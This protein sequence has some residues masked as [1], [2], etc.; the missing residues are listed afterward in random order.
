M[1]ASFHYKK[2]QDVFGG[3]VDVRL[4]SDENYNNRDIMRKFPQVHRDTLFDDTATLHPDAATR[5]QAVFKENGLPHIV[6]ELHPA[7]T[8]IEYNFEEEETC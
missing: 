1:I 7:G 6:A 5:L 8:L 2:P 4:T 3:A